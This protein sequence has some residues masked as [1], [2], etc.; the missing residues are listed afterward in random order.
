MSVDT[1]VR[2]TFIYLVYG[3][4]YLPV[5]HD[6]KVEVFRHGNLPGS[7]EFSTADKPLREIVSSPGKFLTELHNYF[8]DY[9]LEALA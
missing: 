5:F 8:V 2:Y 3:N 9:D 4:G 7:Y 1:Y 6:G